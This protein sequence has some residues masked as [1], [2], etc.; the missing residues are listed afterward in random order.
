MLHISEPLTA[1]KAVNY[2]RQEYAAADNSYYTQGQT[3]QGH[4]HGQFA[5]ELGLTGAVA[6]EDFERMAHGQNPATGEQ[7]I[8]H[9]NTKKTQ[10]GAELEHR[11]GFDLTF[12]APKT[13]SLVALPGHDDRVRQAHA[14][15]VHAAL[16]AGQEYM[17]ARMGGNKLSQTTGKWAAALFEHDTARPENGY[18]APH[19][20][21]HVVVFNMTPTEDGQVRSMQPAEMFRIQS[22]L[23]AVYQNELAVRLKGL[24][25]E[26]TSGTNHAPDIQGFSKEYLEAESQRSQRIKVEMEAKGLEGRDAKN[27]IAHSARE[28]KLK[29]TPEQVHAAHRE[30][31]A[32]FGD[33][34][35]KVHAQSLARKGI[36]LHTGEA[37]T[38]A[39]ASVDF[40]LNKLSERTAIFDQWQTYR[41]A[42]RHGQGKLGLADVRDEVARREGQQHLVKIDHVRQFAP[43]KRY[44][45]AETIAMERDILRHIIRTKETCPQLEHWTASDVG[46]RFPQLNQ[47]QRQ[48]VANVLSSRDAFGSMRGMAGVGKTTTL[49]AIQPTLE[50]HGYEVVGLAATSGAVKAMQAAGVEARTIQLH[51]VQDQPSAQPRYYVLDEASLAST[52][53]VHELMQKLKPEDRVLFVGDTRQHESVEA[54]RIYAQMRE[55]GMAGTTLRQIVRQKDPELK[56]AVE[57]L[58]AGKIDSAVE[59]LQNQGRVHEFSNKNERY[60]AIAKEYASSAGR[61]LIVSPDNESR[62]AINKVVREHLQLSGPEYRQQ[63]LVARQDLTQEDRK[64]AAGYRAGDVIKFHKNNKTLGV[65]KGDYLSVIAVDRINNLITVQAGA[66]IKTYNPERAY[67]VQVYERGERTFAEGERVQLTA[68]WKSK[69][70]ANRQ[71]GT[72]E[73]VDARGNVTM[74]LDGEQ[75]QQRLRVDLP[76]VKQVDAESYAST[77]LATMNQV[78]A[79]NAQH[80]VNL[81]ETEQVDAKSYAAMRPDGDKNARRVRFNL[82]EMK[83]LDYGYAVTSFSSQGATVEKVLVNVSTQDSRVQKLIDQRFAYVAVSRAES[84]A[85]IYTDNAERLAQALGQRQDKTQALRPEEVQTYR[86]QAIQIRNNQLAYGTVV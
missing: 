61:T 39:K 79:A 86:E 12:N 21:T 8:Q 3:L 1:G 41:E 30:H 68:P 44:A 50:Q 24:G 77:K 70:L 34:A 46:E 69:G 51:L 64:I 37:Q 56:R 14:A 32:L 47:A 18:P 71:M 42:L 73:R 62:Q 85:Q 80:R 11:A 20:H 15:A 57:N 75:D 27:S 19:L 29:W 74:R 9:R 83:H 25:Y 31:Q 23:T 38:Q 60:E 43:G 16:D 45:T 40:A 66:Q 54:G 35:D 6:Q 76:E 10:N 26:L 58:S 84:D 17:Q 4:W 33:Q 13:V 49:K 5:E 22:Y 55:A 82:S 81:P 7:W 67:G 48:T 52:R 59:L 78:A 2:F 36:H 65:D 72:L 63:I 28:N 53:M